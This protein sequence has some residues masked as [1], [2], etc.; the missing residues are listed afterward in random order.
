MVEM[1]QKTFSL[2]FNDA[3][4]VQLPGAL[5]YDKQMEMNTSSQKK[6]N[7]CKVITKQLSD[8]SPKN[9]LLISANI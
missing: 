3:C 9:G 4:N 6:L 8:P 7:Y 1:L 2:I 5:V